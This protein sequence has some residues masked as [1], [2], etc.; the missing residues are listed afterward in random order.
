[1]HC[2]I[3]K[4]II[5]EWLQFDR[6]AVRPT[7]FQ[8]IPLK[9]KPSIP[10]KMACIQ[11]QAEAV[12]A[13]RTSS[14]SGP[15]PS[16]RKLFDNEGRVPALKEAVMITINKI[17]CPVDFFP[18]SDAAVNYAAGLAANYD[19]TLHLLHV[20]AP[21]I[22]G[23]FEFPMATV[24]ITKSVEESCRRELKVLEEALRDTGVRVQIDLRSGDV[25]DEIKRV[26]EIEKPDL[27]VM[28]THGRRGAERWFMGST[29]EKMLR[30]TP[31][32][33]VTI[34]ATGDKAASPPRFRRI[35]VTTDFSDGTPD[36]LAY[37]FSVAQENESNVTLLHVLHDVSMDLSGKYRE[38]LISGVQKQ[39]DEMVPREARNWCEINT[40][41]ETGVPYRIIL[42]TLEEEKVDLLVMNIHGKGM[43]DRALLGSTAERVVRAASCP[44][45]MI[46]PMKRKLKRKARPGGNH[47]AA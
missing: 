1:M 36:A 29:T 47:V 32:P 43:L 12:R 42:R 6:M 28:G 9:D 25:Y 5:A 3:G 4:R 27:L 22:P 33:L 23:S 11:M 40:R 30:H 2:Q 7:G 10:R 20:M 8:R 21:V 46:P 39:L 34:S 24:D 44:V 16:H 19:A 15:K 18:A 26:I 38:S 13:A 41:V 45:M 35:L 31:V 37:A 14:C 17:L